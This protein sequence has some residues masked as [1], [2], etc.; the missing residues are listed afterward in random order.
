[1]VGE[2]EEEQWR[3]NLEFVAY[4]VFVVMS[5]PFTHLVPKELEWRTRWSVAT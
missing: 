5:T 3:S 4:D 2:V 1:M